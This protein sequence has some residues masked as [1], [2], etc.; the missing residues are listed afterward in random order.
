MLE[1]C[2]M[3][4]KYILE[5]PILLYFVNL[6]PISCLRLFDEKDFLWNLHLLQ[7]LVQ[8][9]A[10]FLLK[11]KSRA[12]KLQQRLKFDLFQN[13]LFNTL[14]LSTIFVQKSVC[15]FLTFVK[16]STIFCLRLSGKTCFYF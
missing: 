11:F 8:Q 2:K 3:S 10:I 16:F 5:N 6:A 9:K 13:A 14:A 15:I 4:G 1:N 7:I 12:K